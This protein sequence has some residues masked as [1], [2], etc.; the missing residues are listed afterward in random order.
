MYRTI[1]VSVTIGVFIWSCSNT[2]TS[3]T[4]ETNTGVIKIGVI[5]DAGKPYAV[6]RL[7]ALA[8]NKDLLATYDITTLSVVVINSG[9]N[10]DSLSKYD[11]IYLSEDW[12]TNTVPVYENISKNAGKYLTFIENGG[13]LF[14]EQPNPYDRLPDGKITLDFLPIP[15]TISA[16]WTPESA[17]ILNSSH[18]ITS[19]IDSTD[20]PIPADQIDNLNPEY[21]LLAKGDKTGYPALFIHEYGK[22]KIL[23]SM[24]SASYTAHQVYSET[25]HIKMLSWLIL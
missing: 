24:G 14:I 20:M 3:I 25:V 12:A 15:V 13:G 21:T 5:N 16:R 1:I 8:A 22:G 9:I 23:F 4:E 11:I 2:S 17:I 18:Y 6:Q 10:P 19:G 7:N